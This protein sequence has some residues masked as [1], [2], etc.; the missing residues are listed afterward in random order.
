MM[1]HYGS[2]W[3]MLTHADSLWVMLCMARYGHLFSYQRKSYNATTHYLG[4]NSWEFHFHIWKVA[5]LWLCVTMVTIPKCSF[6]MFETIL[7]NGCMLPWRQFWVFL[8]SCLIGKVS[9]TTCLEPLWLMLCKV[10]WSDLPLWAVTHFDSFTLIWT[11]AV[12]GHMSWVMWASRSH[13]LTSLSDT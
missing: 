8:S 2:H 10:T 12:Q 1:T 11:H 6:F 5:V 3:L 9:E 13:M 4:N 7:E